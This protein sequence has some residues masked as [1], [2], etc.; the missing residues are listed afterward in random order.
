MTTRVYISGALTSVPDPTRIKAFYEAIGDVCHKVGFDVYLP[1]LNSDPQKHPDL[2]P[3]QVFELD[4]NKVC[5]SDLVTAYVGIPS[6]GVGMELAYAESAGIP[7][8]LLCEQETRISRFPLGIPTLVETIRFLDFEDAL[9]KLR[10]RLQSITSRTG[11]VLPDPKQ[12]Q[13]ATAR[14]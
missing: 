11:L 4:K 8:I 13:S 9:K 3:R 6:L 14:R 7:I 2:T 1:H 12:S 5:A 10:V